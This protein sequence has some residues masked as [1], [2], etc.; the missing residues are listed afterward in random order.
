MVRLGVHSCSPSSFQVHSCWV[1][2]F[3]SSENLGQQEL[4]IG[5]IEICVLCL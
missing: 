4:L 1:C 3:D 5:F 2:V